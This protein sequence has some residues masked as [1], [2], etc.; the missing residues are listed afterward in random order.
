MSPGSSRNL[1]EDP[2]DSCF[3]LDE[4]LNR[5]P[6]ALSGGAG[7]LRAGGEIAARGGRAARHPRG[8]ALHPPGTRAEA[9][10]RAVAPAR[11][12]SRRSGR[13]RGCAAALERRDPRT[14]DGARRSGPRSARCRDAEQPERSATVSSLAERVIKMMFLARLTLLVAAL[15][16]AASGDRRPSCSHRPT[17]AAESCAARSAKSGSG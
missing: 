14:A 4:E 11:G 13:S 5:L 12:H 9:A 8:H 1:A 17:T 10:P 6:R 16:A 7:G 3:V 15:L 2:D